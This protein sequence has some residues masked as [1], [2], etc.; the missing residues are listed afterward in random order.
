MEFARIAATT[1]ERLAR[2]KLRE[3]EC[4]CA[5][6][7]AIAVCESIDVGVGHYISGNFVCYECGW[8]SDAD[9]KMNVAEYADY[10]V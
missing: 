8:E 9:G 4:A 3:Y 7:P 6:C 1:T 5:E 10:F 2:G